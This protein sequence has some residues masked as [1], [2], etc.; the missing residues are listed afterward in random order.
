MATGNDDALW[1]VPL[2]RRF[3]SCRNVWIADLLLL[4]SLY[5]LGFSNREL[6]NWQRFPGESSDPN[7]R[8]VRRKWI[9]AEVMFCDDEV[10]RRRR[11]WGFTRDSKEGS[12]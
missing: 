2:I 12:E 11:K 4:E 7:V 3:W 1:A 6:R 9:D 8:R 10:I 5:V